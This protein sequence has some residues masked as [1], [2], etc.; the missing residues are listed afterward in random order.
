MP[1]ASGAPFAS[2]CPVPL[3]ASNV[4]VRRLSNADFAFAPQSEKDPVATVTGA[5][6]YIS[7]EARAGAVSSATPAAAASAQDAMPWE[8][9]IGRESFAQTLCRPRSLYRYMDE[10][11]L[12]AQSGDRSALGDLIRLAWPDA[13]RLAYAVLG[14]RQ[15][16]E[17]A[18]QEACVAVCRSI[19]SLRSAGAFRVWLYRIVVREASRVRGSWREPLVQPRDVEYCEEHDRGIDIWNALAQLPPALREVVVLRYFEDL[20]SSE[21]ASIVGI[22]APTVRFRLMRA[23]RRL[24]PLLDD[25]PLSRPVCE[26][27]G[28]VL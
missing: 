26:V 18:A 14:Q 12:A 20:N 16:A 23:K 6:A 7:T 19:A 8:A 21:I 24:R 27:S 1:F 10:V 5:P 17:D 28:H 22:P 9:V 2:H 25:A 11:I 4:P 3:P 15:H 13:Y